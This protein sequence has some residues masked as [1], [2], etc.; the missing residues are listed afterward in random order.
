LRPPL[1]GTIV[2][3]TYD[4][5]MIPADF[6]FP[7]DEW[8]RAGSNSTGEEM[9]YRGLRRVLV[10]LFPDAESVTAE[11]THEFLKHLGIS[12]ATITR[13]RHVDGAWFYYVFAEYNEFRARW[14]YNLP[15]V[16]PVN[17]SPLASLFRRVVRRRTRR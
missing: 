16:L 11:A 13:G 4:C 6:E 10:R 9:L 8:K 5:A 15:D 1:N 14:P 17:E 7:I 12:S 2:R 3:R